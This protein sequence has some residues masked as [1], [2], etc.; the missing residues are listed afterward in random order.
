[1]ITIRSLE[2]KDIDLLVLEY[3]KYFN[4][5]ENMTWNIETATKNLRQ[6]IIREDFLGLIMLKENDLVGFA[7]GQLS[8]FDDGIVYELNE[9]FISLDYQH[10]GY[11]SILLNEVEDLA[12]KNGCFRIQ[13]ITAN[14]KNHNHFYDELHGFVTGTNNIIKTK[15][16]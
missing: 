15:A 8:Q 12:R 3:I 11:G 6:L 2:T 7:C 5:K 14:D 10:H 13:L 9:L 16:L 1:M 4:L